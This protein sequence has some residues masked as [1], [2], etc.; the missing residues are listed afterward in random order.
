MKVVR[1][2]GRETVYSSNVYLVLGSWNKLDDVNTLVD[3][4]PDGFVLSEVWSLSTGVGK[5]PVEQVVL[6]HS[7]S[8]HAG[9]VG[10]IKGALNPIVIAQ[11]KCPGVDRIVESGDIIRMGDREF[12]VLPVPDHSSDSVCLL[13]CEEGVVF[14]G[15]TT[16]SLHDSSESHSREFIAFLERLLTCRVRLIYPGHGAAIENG[17]EHMIS[18]S[19]RIAKGGMCLRKPV[20]V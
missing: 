19:L 5:V 16:L 12:E 2:R 18:E 14:T 17:V 20:S 3:V 1:L 10:T 9:G 4:G 7:H 6:T 11:T 15:D 13:C 8:D